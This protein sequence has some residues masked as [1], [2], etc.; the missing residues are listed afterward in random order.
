MMKEVVTEEVSKPAISIGQDKKHIT[1]G[2]LTQ[3]FFTLLSRI[4]GMV[5]EVMIS[6]I[7]GATSTTDAFFIAFT[8]PNVLRQFFGEGSFSVAFVP[9]Y[10]ATKEKEGLE[11]AKLFF[12]HA[13]GFLLLSLGLV[14][15]FGIWNANYFVQLFAYGFVDSP[16]QLLL[17]QKLTSW[18]FPYVF[19]ISIVA[20]FGAHLAC[21][22]RFAAMSA[23]PIL[24]NIA[25]IIMMT[26]FTSYFREP[27]MVL[28]AGIILGGIF[29]VWLMVIALKR[30]GLWLWPQLSFK[31]KAM[32]HF[33]GLLAPSLFGI[34][35]YQLNIIVLRQLASF[36][37]EGQI[38]YYY[39]ADRLTQFAI[40]VFG[41]SIA[42]AA[43][44][45]LSRGISKYGEQAF[46]DTLRFTFRI[47]SFVMTPC[48]VGL[49]I[50]AEPIISVIYVH[51]AFTHADAIITAHTL[52]AFAP[53]LIPFS[54]SRPLIQAFYA[55]GNTRIPVLVGALTVLVNL[56]LGFLCLRFE[57][58]G[59][60]MTLSASSLVQYTALLWCFK[61]YSKEPFKTKIMPSFLTHLAIAVA[62]SGLGLMLINLGAWEQGFSLKNMMILVLIAGIC[63][64]SYVSLTY[65]FGLNESRK[66]LHGIK[67]RLFPS[68]RSR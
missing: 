56:V 8:I 50:F 31:T 15:I 1:I 43:L 12:R 34:F 65:A 4:F 40:G 42:T 38:S 22:R 45:E 3:A 47:I 24:L 36:L 44:P 46:F 66:L 7:F 60:A 14:T 6:H 23:A 51:G 48:T 28:A 25:S 53:S 19:M 11:S 68:E 30:A 9:V 17:T 2:A 20:L 54:L 29:Q 58:V 61:R 27:V 5:R 64:I 33:L 10:V 55:Q 39:N 63:G 52:M 41:V 21:Y 16:E 35:V 67:E 37:G 26:S 57:V 62:S 32:R 59:L 13:F 18:M 49:M